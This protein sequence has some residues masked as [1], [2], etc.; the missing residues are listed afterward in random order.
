MIPRPSLKEHC[1]SLFWAVQSQN[2]LSAFNHSTVVCEAWHHRQR[3]RSVSCA[4]I[5]IFW[6]SQQRLSNSFVCCWL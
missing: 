1:G 3:K 6:T 4:D 5:S 2:I